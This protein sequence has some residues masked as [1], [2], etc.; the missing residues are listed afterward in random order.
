MSIRLT[1]FSIYTG[2]ISVA[3]FQADIDEIVLEER[4]KSFCQDCVLDP[5]TCGRNLEEC[6]KEA[7]L[8]F[9]LYDDAKTGQYFTRRR[10]RR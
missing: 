9:N 6:M 1:S 7:G 5:E 8:Y 4:K 10:V 2:R 3:Y